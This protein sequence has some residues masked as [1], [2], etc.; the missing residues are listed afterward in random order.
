MPRK[1]DPLLALLDKLINKETPASVQYMS[2][3]ICIS[4]IIA[5]LILNQWS[6]I[7]PRWS[8]M[9]IIEPR[10]VCM[11]RAPQITESE[12]DFELLPDVS[13]NANTVG[14]NAPISRL[15]RLPHSQSHS[16]V[17]ASRFKGQ[18]GLLCRNNKT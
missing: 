8:N 16:E 4:W 3:E 10:T 17:N 2:V 1:P 14:K 5:G 7:Y 13:P 6:D 18:L 15:R 9:C 11:L 12:R